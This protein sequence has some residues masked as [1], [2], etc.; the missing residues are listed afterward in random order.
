MQAIMET[1]FDILYLTTVV[2]LGI[3]MLRRCKGEKQYLLFGIMA[4]T[5]GLG[6]AFHL[7]PRAYALCTTGLENHVAALG[8]GKFIT[9]LTMTV[10][11]VLLYYVWRLRYQ[12]T[13]RRGLTVAIYGLAALRLILCLLP[14]NRW[15]SPDAPLS[16]GV[17]R[18]IPFALL[19]LVIIV[20]FYQSAKKH[21]DKAFRFL[22]LTVVLSFAFYIPVV[23]FADAFPLIG[24]L[25]IPKTCAYV[26]T[27]LIGY[28]A[29]KGGLNL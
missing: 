2:T 17:Y 4:I 15:T 23:L 22:W 16:W 10:F 18:N 19:G 12:V 26:W 7:V 25:M 5:L 11:Y 29:M 20:L 13:G 9:S 8:T 6:D 1:V 28:Q 14:Q 21:N 27:V 24:M 3:L